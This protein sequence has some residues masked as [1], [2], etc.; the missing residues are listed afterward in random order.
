MEQINSKSMLHARHEYLSFVILN[1]SNVE[2]IP[3][4]YDEMNSQ[5]NSS[6]HFHMAK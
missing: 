5:T 3:K 1:K 6:V 2:L 4:S